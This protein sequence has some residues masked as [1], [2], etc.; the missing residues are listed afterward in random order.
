ML[1]K[2]KTFLDKW[3][4]IFLDI[5]I[6]TVTYLALYS[7][8]MFSATDV[9]SWLIY[10]V[11]IGVFVRT[12]FRKNKYKKNCI[13]FSGIFSFMMIIG[14]V[15]YENL[16]SFGNNF[17]LLVQPINL[18]YFLGIFN[19]FYLLFTWTLP[20]LLELKISQN[21]NAPQK[22]NLIF[23]LSAIIILLC[24]MPYFLNF[25]P[26]LLSNDSINQLEIILDGFS[27]I[28]D[29]HPVLH[30]IF[31]A[32]PYCIGFGLSNSI[33]TGVAFSTFTQMICLSLTFAY[34]I[35]F[36]YERN[37][38]KLALI[39][40]VLFYAF[41]PVFGYYSVT[42]W[43]DVMFGGFLLLL[44]IETVKLVEKKE[45]DDLKLKE[46]F[47]FILVSLLCVFFRNNAIY[48]Y[49]ILVLATFLLPKRFWKKIL[50]CMFF[51]IAFYFVIKGPIFDALHIKKSSSAEYIGM[52]LQQIGRMAYKEV[53]F[54]DEDAKLLNELIPIEELKKTYN[55]KLSDGIKFNSK[56]NVDVFNNNKLEYLKLYVSL[57]L[58][59]P[60]IAAEAYL[61]STLGYWYP[62]VVHWTVTTEIAENNIGLTT[63]PITTPL[64]DKIIRALGSRSARILTITWSIALC[65]WIILIFG[66]ITK[67]RKGLK[68]I[69]AFVPVFGI[70]AT[71][72]LASPVY[73]EF[74]YIFGAYTCLPLFVILPFLVSKEK[75]Y[76]K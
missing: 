6:A 63:N 62:G 48:M 60:E 64:L 8:G 25:Y 11:L 58:K 54:T 18:L 14:E 7:K 73:G 28:S 5:V 45:E 39:M 40:I 19:I 13:A 46:L 47:R 42:M 59:H 4:K 29:H 15:M 76:K 70:W 31:I 9:Q 44:T 12:D 66:Y 57:V 32:I 35:K 49:M 61:I 24:Q 38:N 75:E 69:Y 23:V 1:D 34:L 27:N 51:V 65:F 26:G 21:I 68:Y 53:E 3:G 20:Y 16:Y 52:P 50:A 67:K 30:T 74:R 10:F 43:K 56:F 33:E 72:L 55:P 36:L 22:A 2:I 41:L 71:M 17:K 37:V